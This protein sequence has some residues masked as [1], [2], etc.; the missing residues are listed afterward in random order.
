MSTKPR[1]PGLFSYETHNYPDGTRKD[2]QWSVGGGASL[3]LVLSIEFASH[4]PLDHILALLVRW[5]VVMR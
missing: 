3:I 1:L 4:V 2:V 5:L